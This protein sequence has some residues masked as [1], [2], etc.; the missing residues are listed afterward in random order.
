MSFVS[1]MS[2]KFKFPLAHRGDFG[3]ISIAASKAKAR[4]KTY[5]GVV[6]RQTR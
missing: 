2:K 5:V 3:N 4:S 6:E 1:V